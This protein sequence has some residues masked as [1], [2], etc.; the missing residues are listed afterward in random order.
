M[1]IRREKVDYS[2]RSRQGFWGGGE[3]GYLFSGSWGALSDY[4]FLGELESKLIL[5]EF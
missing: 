3:K 2:K 1:K 4:M 5:L